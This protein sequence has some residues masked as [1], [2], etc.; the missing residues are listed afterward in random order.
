MYR[1]FVAKVS[2]GREPHV[3][4][5]WTPGHCLDHRVRGKRHSNFQ[6]CWPRPPDGL[7][8]VV[9]S[10]FVR[11]QGRSLKPARLVPAWDLVAALWPP[12]KEVLGQNATRYHTMP[13][14]GHGR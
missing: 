10:Q 12:A 14:R 3:S 6:R 8:I 13:P 11:R 5:L 7:M 1:D 9:G 4:T 2:S